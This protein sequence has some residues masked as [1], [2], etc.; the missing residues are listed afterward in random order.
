MLKIDMYN[1]KIEEHKEK[2]LNHQYSYYPETTAFN[3]L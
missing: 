1:V 3:I 2:N